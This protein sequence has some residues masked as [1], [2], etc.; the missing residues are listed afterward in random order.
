MSAQTLRRTGT[1]PQ[2]EPTVAAER[3]L[4]SRSVMPSSASETTS[5]RPTDYVELSDARTAAAAYDI[6][7]VARVHV[8]STGG[9]I[10]NSDDSMTHVGIQ[11]ENIGG[12]GIA[13]DG[14]TFELVIFHECGAQLPNP[15]LT[16]IVPLGPCHLLIPPGTS[17]TFDLC[18]KL[19]VHPQLVASMRAS[20]FILAAEER[21][22]RTT[23]FVR[24][25]ELR[26]RRRW[27]PLGRD[28]RGFEDR[29][30]R[31]GVANDAE[32][33]PQPGPPNLA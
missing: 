11:I 18:F 33:D 14:T 29:S 13:F 9:F 10:S 8:W 25:D 28:A 31:S 16:S 20:W 26:S 1:S 22:G 3:N 17:V 12:H 15:T 30:E 7:D 23:N 19:A 32:Q 5:F 4:H 6:Q 27:P 24:D 21:I 2:N